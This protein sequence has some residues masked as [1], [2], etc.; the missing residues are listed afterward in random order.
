[1]KNKKSVPVQIKKSEDKF[2]V[3]TIPGIKVTKY[4]IPKYNGFICKSGVPYSS[5]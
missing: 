4:N 5:T 3:G 1:M 2:H